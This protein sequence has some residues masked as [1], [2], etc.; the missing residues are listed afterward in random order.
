VPT[1]PVQLL[2]VALSPGVKRPGPKVD[3][4]PSTF[5]TQK[6]KDCILPF[7]QTYRKPSLTT[8]AREV[9]Y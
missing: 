9:I 2:P 5:L 8:H 1:R 3:N 6:R 7:R 4:P